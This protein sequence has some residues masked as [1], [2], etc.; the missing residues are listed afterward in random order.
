MTVTLHQGDALE[1][2]PDLVG[3]ADLVISDHPY[4][5]TSGGNNQSMSGMFDPDE[6]DN[7]GSLMETV[8]WSRI[9]GPLYRACKPNADCYVMANDKNIFMAHAGFVGAGWKFHNML[10]WDKIYPTRNRWY[11]KHLEYT[12]YFWKGH[13]RVI[14]N[15]GSKQLFEQSHRNKES[16]HPT[17]KPIELMEHYILNSTNPGDTVLDPFMG[18]GTTGVAALRT[19]R[20]FIG[21]EL[22]DH[23]FATAKERIVQEKVSA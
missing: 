5:L 6:Y 18:S 3:V 20:K 15:P 19:G 9:G 7:S 13:A 23:H 1:I 21:I 12:L 22:D 11:M 16:D 14:N 4:K 8:E 2:L 17:E 10:A